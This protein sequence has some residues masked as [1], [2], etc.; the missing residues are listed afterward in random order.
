MAKETLENR[1]KILRQAV[2]LEQFG[3]QWLA[4]NWLGLSDFI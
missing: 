2:F 1:R 3:T 4:H